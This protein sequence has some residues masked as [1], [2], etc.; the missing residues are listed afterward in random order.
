MSVSTYITLWQDE[1]QPD[2][3]CS[4]TLEAEDFVN[5]FNVG[6]ILSYDVILTDSLTGKVVEN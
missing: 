5:D 1:V 6:D 3:L 4:E 2:I